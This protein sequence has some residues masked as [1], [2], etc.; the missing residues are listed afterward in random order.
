M[1]RPGQVAAVALGVFLFTGLSSGRAAAAAARE[2]RFEGEGYARIPF[3][4][5][6]SHVWV[7][8]TIGSSDS[9]WIVIDTGASSGLL[10]SGVAR[11]LG[12]VE[13]GEQRS[14]GA[15]G[16]VMGRWVSN[17]DIHL[18]GLTVHREQIPTTPLVDIST[19]G[20]RPM[21]L[22]IGHELFASCV[23]RFDYAAG[24]LEVWDL[25]HAP[26]PVPGESVPLK[27]LQDLPY[28]DGVL[29]V[30]GRSPIRGRFQLDT[31]SAAALMVGAD[32]TER[33]RLAAAFPRTLEQLA[34]GVGGA[35]RNRV[36]RAA[37]FSVGTLRFDKPTVAMQQAGVG[38]ISAPGTVGNMGGQLLG[39]CRVT[40]DYA[41]RRV[42]LEPGAN[43]GEPF[44]A[45]MS[46]ATITFD[47]N[48]WG[49]RI[50]NPETPAAEA[51]LRAGDAVVHVNGEPAERLDPVALRRLLS[52][53]G[54][55]VTIG[56]RRGAE[57]STVTLRL[58]RL[59]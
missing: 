54:A 46:G 29:E 17:V 22:I 32:V 14:R 59:I 44:E 24:A 3:D 21:Q 57:E 45:D 9:L 37:S 1:P 39:R 2:V 56:I 10:D 52:T 7:R 31:G 40:F 25:D 51:G 8:G 50:V 36:G 53:E 26:N 4:L 20:R 27:L 33:E 16:A 47:G 48:G 18:P 49:V 19:A 38:R 12:L 28:V 58:R 35:M 30:P 23:V 43:F 55:S 11:S 42:S 34:R 41:H 13:H 15:G 5:R 6:G